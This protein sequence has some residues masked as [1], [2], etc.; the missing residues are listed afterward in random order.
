M[1]YPPYTIEHPGRDDTR[2]FS[3]ISTMSLNWAMNWAKT[4]YGVNVRKNSNTQFTVAYRT[5][6]GKESYITA[7]HNPETVQATLAS[8]YSDPNHRGQGLG[9]ALR[10]IA[11][12]ILYL[13][14]YQTIRHQ[15]VNKEGLVGPNEYPISTK[16]VRKHLG[17]RRFRKNEPEKPSNQ[18]SH[19]GSPSGE[20]GYNSKWVPNRRS[21]MTLKKTVRKSTLK[22]K[23]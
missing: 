17:F 13:G 1:V 12:W 16:I 10:A 9:T 14:G 4:R 20:F 18:Y 5:P 15:G 3:N 8:G 7:K 11:T 6:N 23:K 22:L 19:K 21:V 2:F